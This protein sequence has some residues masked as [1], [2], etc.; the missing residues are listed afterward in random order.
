MKLLILSA[1]GGSGHTQAAKALLA[2]AQLD[3]Q[4]SDV[5]HINIIPFFSNTILSFLLSIYEYSIINTP[6]VWG[7]FYNRLNNK[8]TIWFTRKY[9]IPL[10]KIIYKKRITAFSLEIDKYAPDW[11]ICTHPAVRLTFANTNYPVSMV[12][13]DYGLHALWIFNQGD[14]Y[15][16]PNVEVKKELEKYNIKKENCVVSGIPVHPVFY[17]KKDINVLRQKYNI[18]NDKKTILILTGGGGLFDPSLYIQALNQSIEPLRIIV[19]AGKNK[20]L[21][22]KLTKISLSAQHEYR[23]L[24][25]TDTIDEY[26]RVADYVVTKPG[27]LTTSEC[28][29]LQKPMILISPILGQEEKNLDFLCRL[30]VAIYVT[31]PKEILIKIKNGVFSPFVIDQAGVLILDTVKNIFYKNKKLT[32]F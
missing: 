5:R 11:I 31:K 19:V 16:A 27:G 1:P 7:E 29:A 17:E 4:I 20:V 21:H 23:V 6:K 24:G 26:M 2:T 30:G 12:I 25:W 3:Q 32:I 9:I 10:F 22:K 18:S 13:T 14:L 28:L 15:F 8:M